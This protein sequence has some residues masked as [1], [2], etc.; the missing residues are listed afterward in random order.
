MSLAEQFTFRFSKEALAVAIQIGEVELRIVNEKSVGRVFEHALGVHGRRWP[1]LKLHHLALKVGKAGTE[2]PDVV[3][4]YVFGLA[5]DAHTVTSQF[6]PDVQI[7]IIK[8]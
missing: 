1:R 6:P 7:K 2:L 8:I 3:F 5:W 4:G